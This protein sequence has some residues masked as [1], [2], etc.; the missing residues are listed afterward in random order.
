MNSFKNAILERRKSA[1]PES[2]RKSPDRKIDVNKLP[3]DIFASKA[4]DAYKSPARV[5]DNSKAKKPFKIYTETT[6]EEKS[7]RINQEKQ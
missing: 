1:Q 3:D 7:A 2:L 5:Q 6:D 4:K